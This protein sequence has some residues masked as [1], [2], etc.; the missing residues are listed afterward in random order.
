VTE[1]GGLELI[2]I[3]AGTFLIG[4]PPSE[5]GRYDDEGPQH[6]ANLSSFYLGRYQ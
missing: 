5:K 6:S 2:P 1:N 4:S 3:P